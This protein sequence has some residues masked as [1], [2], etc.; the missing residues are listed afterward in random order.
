MFESRHPHAAIKVIDFGLSKKYSEERKILTERVGTLYSMSP[1]TMKGMYTDR[2]DIW[3][4]AVITYMLLSGGDKPFEGKTPKELI[5]KVLMGDYTFDS[6]DHD[7]NNRNNDN[8]NIDNTGAVVAAAA[9]NVWDGISDSAKSF[10]RSLLVVNPAQRPSAL[11]AMEHEWIRTYRDK[12][13]R[14]NQQTTNNTSSETISDCQSVDSSDYEIGATETGSSS[15]DN[16]EDDQ[17]VTTSS[18]RS[19]P[20]VDEE[21]KQRVRENIIQYADAGE[22]RKLALNVIAKKSVSPFHSAT[23]V[24]LLAMSRCFYCGSYSS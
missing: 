11:Q 8:T 5:A 6:R 18:M 4:L 21:L 19:I 23:F 17:D 1:E 3:S 22:F 14:R 15:N 20:Q 10:V 12:M 13:H 9:T 24:V 7:N 2:A 16:D